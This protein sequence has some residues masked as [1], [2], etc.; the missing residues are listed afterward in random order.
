MVSRPIQHR[1]TGIVF[2][3]RVAVDCIGTDNRKHGNRIT[4]A[5]E[6]KKSDAKTL[7]L[8]KTNINYKTLQVSRF[9]RHPASKLSVSIL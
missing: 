1:S 2:R 3:R 8:A 9:L 5:H 6:T 4:H 7:P